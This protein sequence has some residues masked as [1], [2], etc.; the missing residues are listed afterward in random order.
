MPVVDVDGVH[1]AREALRREIAVAHADLFTR[2]RDQHRTAAGPFAPTAEG[3]GHRALANGALAY[4]AT[5][6]A[7]AALAAEQY[8]TADNHDRP[9]GRPAGSGGP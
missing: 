4:L 2:L 9:Y 8:D 3:A 5:D 1:A 6:P 7:N